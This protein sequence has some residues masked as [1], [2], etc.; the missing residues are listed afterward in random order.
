MLPVELG[1]TLPSGDELAE[2]MD[3]FFCDTFVVFG[4]DFYRPDDPTN[5]VEALK[6]ANWPL[7]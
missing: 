2:V 5:S 4:D 1:G 7:R 3:L 6:E